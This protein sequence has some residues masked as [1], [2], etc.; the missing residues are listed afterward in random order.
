MLDS[1]PASAIGCAAQ[2]LISSLA[3]RLKLYHPLISGATFGRSSGTQVGPPG[4]YSSTPFW[5]S[6]REGHILRK[7]ALSR[8]CASLDLDLSSWLTLLQRIS[9]GFKAIEWQIQA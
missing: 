4:D 3:S 5:H 1:P 7:T 8:E 6:L 9:I 2:F